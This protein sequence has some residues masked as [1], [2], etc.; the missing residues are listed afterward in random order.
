M[1]WRVGLDGEA[2][3]FLSCREESS[4]FR[5]REALSSALVGVHMRKCKKVKV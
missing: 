3:S 4:R 5:A 2:C 1:G